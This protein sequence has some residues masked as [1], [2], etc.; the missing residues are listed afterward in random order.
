MILLPHYLVKL[1]NRNLSKIAKKTIKIV[2]CFTQTERLLLMVEWIIDIVWAV[3]RNVHIRLHKSF[4]TS[5]QLVSCAFNDVLHY[6]VLCSSKLCTR[7]IDPLLDG[8]P[9]LVVHWVDVGTVQWPHIWGNECLRC[10]FKKSGSVALARC[11]GTPSC[12]KTKNVSD[13]SSIIGSS[14]YDRITLR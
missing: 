7:V 8:A 4:K 13:T 1:K 6:A 12:C 14:C 5:A 9:D 10:F 3:V 11:A 2:A